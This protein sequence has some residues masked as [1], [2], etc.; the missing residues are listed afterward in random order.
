MNNYKYSQVVV[1]H[2]FN[3]SGGMW[4]SELQDGLVYKVK[5]Q[6]SMGYTEKNPVSKKKK[7]KRGGG[8]QRWLIG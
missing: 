2:I 7:K 4:I 1:A 6:A 8:L 5:F 3:P